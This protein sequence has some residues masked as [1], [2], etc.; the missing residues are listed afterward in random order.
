MTQST[1]P[2]ARALTPGELAGVRSL[3][4]VLDWLHGPDWRP[5]G[6]GELPRDKEREEVPRVRT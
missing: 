2:T 4:L 1:D 6:N 3:D 5:R